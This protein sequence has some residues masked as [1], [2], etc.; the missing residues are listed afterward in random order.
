MEWSIKD[1]EYDDKFIIDKKR[2]KPI[3][4]MKIKC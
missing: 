4:C 3:S 2:K 1:I